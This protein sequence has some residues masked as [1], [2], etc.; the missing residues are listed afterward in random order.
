MRQTT[1]SPCKF[2]EEGYLCPCAMTIRT[3]SFSP[4]VC[5]LDSLGQEGSKVAWSACSRSLVLE[6]GPP[7]FDDFRFVCVCFNGINLGKA[8]W[9]PKTAA[10]RRTTPTTVIS[11]SKWAIL[12]NLCRITLSGFYI[13]TQFVFENTKSKK[14]NLCFSVQK[15]HGK[16]GQQDLNQASPMMVFYTWHCIA[17]HGHVLCLKGRGGGGGYY[18]PLAKPCSPS[19]NFFT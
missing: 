16:T 17:G 1:R 12:P 18:A 13:N 19:Q 10:E 7:E 2:I 8:L 4:V 6:K 3:H 11:T 5:K 9:G 14:N 15:D